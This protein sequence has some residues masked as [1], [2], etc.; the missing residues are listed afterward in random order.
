MDSDKNRLRIFVLICALCLIGSVGYVWMRTGQI[1][2]GA[3]TGHKA[4][5]GA[6]VSSGEVESA[7]RKKEVTGKAIESGGVWPKAPFILFRTTVLD[8]RYGQLVALPVG[9]LAE[10]RTATGLACE[11]AYFAAGQGVCLTAE[12]GAITTYH[13]YLFDGSLR[14][15]H[16]L[17]LQ[18]IPS[19]ARV[20]PDGRYAAITVFTSGHSY[21]PGTFSTRAEIYRTADGSS[22]AELEQFTVE[23]DGKTFRDIDF[24][25]W[26][27]TFAAD[28]NR[29]YATLATGGQNYLVEGDVMAR[30]I[31]IIH[32]G[33]ECPSLSPDG[34][35]IAFKRL[36][37][38]GWHLYVV[39]LI[40]KVEIPL[41]EKRSVDDQ[42]EWLD[43]SHILYAFGDDVWVVP[44]DGG[45]SPTVFLAKAYS[46]AVVR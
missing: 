21:S 9:D 32:A 14:P 18:G 44:A 16:R 29:F 42:V 1:G 19:R 7:P 45:G 31:R 37:K 20:S 30:H 17:P 5:A 46:P 26:G 2:N 6:T 12:R 39:D 36:T 23:R 11:R 24:N 8:E 22:V 35:R 25:F 27:I 4:L 10:S 41:T 28:G 43:D 34:R 13:A 3:A 38:S 33:V 40:K 15:G